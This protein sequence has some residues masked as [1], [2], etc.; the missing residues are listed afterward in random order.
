MSFR[1]SWDI[2]HNISIQGTQ[3]HNTG[4]YVALEACISSSFNSPSREL[5]IQV[6]IKSRTLPWW[7]A[8]RQ[9]P[10]MRD[11]YEARNFFS[12]Q[13]PPSPK[14]RWAQIV[15]FIAPLI[16]L[17]LRKN[18]SVS[19]FSSSAKKVGSETGCTTAGC[20]DTLPTRREAGLPPPVSI[21]SSTV[22]T[23][24]PKLRIAEPL[25][26]D[27]VRHETCV[28]YAVALPPAYVAQQTLHRTSV[29]WEGGRK[30]KATSWRAQM[31]QRAWFQNLRS[32]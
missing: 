11:F 17:N 15:Y 20:F 26:T 32:Q 12:I 10:P 25:L 3:R 13:T 18:P 30:Q 8:T 19:L 23:L 7:V 6:H 5:V 9:A 14:G 16:F 21:H 31:L 2:P 24:R 28:S 29:G 4:N 27:S 1:G 22:Q